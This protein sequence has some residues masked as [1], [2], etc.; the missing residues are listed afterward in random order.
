[1]LAKWKSGVN[2]L[3]RVGNLITN[4]FLRF[5]VREKTLDILCS[6][7]RR[8]HGTLLGIVII[9]YLSHSQNDRKDKWMR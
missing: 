9:L 4:H 1:M 3:T 8:A 5:C 2:C 7:L 6:S